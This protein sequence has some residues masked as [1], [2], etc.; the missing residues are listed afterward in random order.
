MKQYHSL[1]FFVQSNFKNQNCSGEEPNNQQELEEG[2]T[3]SNRGLGI[4][5]TE[6]LAKLLKVQGVFKSLD[7]NNLFYG[8]GE[9]KF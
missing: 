9:L 2:L 7:I 8:V 4:S 3:P 6:E 1:V 5:S